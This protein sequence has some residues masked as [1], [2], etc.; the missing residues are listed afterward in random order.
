MAESFDM[1]GALRFD[2]ARGRVSL[3]GGNER[4][5]AQVVLP[6]EALT[7]LWNSLSSAQLKDFGHTTGTVLGSRVA[8]RL[9]LS[10]P[11][12]EPRD[13]VEHLGGELALSGLGSLTLESWGRALVLAVVG[14]PL[15]VDSESDGVWLAALLDSALT[16]LFSRDLDVVPLKSEGAT[17]RF[18]VCNRSAGAE[19][20]DW[21]AGGASFGQ[22]ME[23]LN[24]AEVQS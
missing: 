21:L 20:R 3:T 13:V 22:V 19:L 8:G 1:S 16:R 5:A 15:R 18:V 6:A 14:S 24:N 9:G 11:G 17:T 10:L 2:L 4:A 23:R 7:A 12:V